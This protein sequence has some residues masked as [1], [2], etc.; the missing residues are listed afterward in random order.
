MVISSSVNGVCINRVIEYLFK[1][2]GNHLGPAITTVKRTVYAYAA[3]QQ[4]RIG[5][6]R[7]DDKGISTVKI[8]AIPMQAGCVPGIAAISTF[9]DP[10]AIRVT[11]IPIACA[12]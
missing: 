11:A 12:Y 8:I 10:Q 9:K 6:N 7:V 2:A 5:I 3:R 4:N 1:V